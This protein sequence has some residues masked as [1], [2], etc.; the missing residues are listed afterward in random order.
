MHH[1]DTGYSI[2]QEYSQPEHYIL[3]EDKTKKAY[4]KIKL[5]FHQIDKVVCHDK[6]VTSLGTQKISKPTST[7]AFFCIERM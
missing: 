4:V 2:C 6:H 5:Y 1:P 7:H 3:W